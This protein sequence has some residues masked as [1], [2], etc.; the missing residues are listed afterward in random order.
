M[1]ELDRI[2][3]LSTA[4]PAVVRVTCRVGAVATTKDIGREACVGRGKIAATTLVAG[5][6]SRALFRDVSLSLRKD[7]FETHRD[8][9]IAAIVDI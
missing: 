8:L 3:H 6:A 1:E 9:T 7:Q 2:A 4:A 5:L